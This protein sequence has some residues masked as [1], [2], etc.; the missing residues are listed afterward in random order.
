MCDPISDLKSC[1][2][3]MGEQGYQPKTVI[4]TRF[5]WY[6]IK[7]ATGL[8]TVAEVKNGDRELYG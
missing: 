8:R 5:M 6:K 3:Y 4:V 1:L 7:Q 2:L